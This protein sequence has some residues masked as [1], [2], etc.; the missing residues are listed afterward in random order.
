MNSGAPSEVDL[1]S[2]HTHTQPLDN[3]VTPIFQTGIVKTATH[4]P[5]KESTGA[6][7]LN[8]QS[9]D[10]EESI[11]VVCKLLGL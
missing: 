4:E 10:A 8:F 9:A 6:V 11:S 7:N 3:P 5:D 2:T 1:W